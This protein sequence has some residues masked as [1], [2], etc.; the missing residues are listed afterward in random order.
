M[1]IAKV[2][3][4]LRSSPKVALLMYSFVEP[5]LFVYLYASICIAVNSTVS[6]L[7][8]MKRTKMRSWF[9]ATDFSSCNLCNQLPFDDA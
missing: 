4:R 5:N 9:F 7:M 8:N 3:V 2:A 6:V 1:F